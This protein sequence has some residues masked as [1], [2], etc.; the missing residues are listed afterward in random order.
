MWRWQAGLLSLTGLSSLSSHL[1]PCP[2]PFYLLPGTAHQGFQGNY[3][4]LKL[5]LR[6]K[7]YQRNAGK[8]GGSR[9]WTRA[10]LDRDDG[11]TNRTFQR[12]VTGSFRV[13]R[14]LRFLLVLPSRTPLLV[15][16]EVRTK[17]FQEKHAISWTCLEQTPSAQRNTSLLPF[18]MNQRNLF[19]ISSNS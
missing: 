12:R 15:K 6:R 1:H 19:V 10:G 7:D 13:T 9:L 14:D 16:C 4:D 17:K 3:R 18:Y 8:K 11:K 5:D 2:L